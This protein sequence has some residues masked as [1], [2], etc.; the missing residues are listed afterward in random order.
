MH[1]STAL[2]GTEFQ[3][4]LSDRMTFADHQAFRILLKE[5]D[6]SDAK[7]CVLELSGLTAIDSAGLGMFIIAAEAGK[8]AG[9]TLSLVAP[10]PRVKQLLLL[11]RFD[12]ILTMKD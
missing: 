12:R 1:I 9:W 7:S 6:D 10:A 4:R 5:I 8:A 3:V 11:A 2:I